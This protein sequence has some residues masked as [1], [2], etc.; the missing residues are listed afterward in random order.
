[1]HTTSEGLVHLTLEELRSLSIVHHASGVDDDIQT[2]VGSCGRAT[3]ISGFTE[4]MTESIPGITLG[5]DWCLQ[6]EGQEVLWQRLG[7][8]R[9]NVWLMDHN[10]SPPNWASSLEQLA[11]VVDALPWTEV[12][13]KALNALHRGSS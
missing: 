13:P 4:W 8:P 11:R 5:W 3:H 7:M 6:V 2:R 1:M 12:V 9:T 10:S